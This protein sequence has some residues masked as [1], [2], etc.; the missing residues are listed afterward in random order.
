MLLTKRD[1]NLTDTNELPQ[2]AHIEVVLVVVHEDRKFIQA[3]VSNQR[4][5]LLYI[6]KTKKHTKLWT[7]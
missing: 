2:N 4:F 5:K 7:Q 6:G 1:K 3:E